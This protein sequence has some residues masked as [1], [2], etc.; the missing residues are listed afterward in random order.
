M[1]KKEWRT[2]HE[3]F[4][5]FVFIIPKYR[6]DPNK[7]SAW[8]KGRSWPVSVGDRI[9]RGRKAR[10]SRAKR[11]QNV[12][13]WDNIADRDRCLSRNR[14]WPRALRTQKKYAQSQLSSPYNNLYGPH[15]A[16]TERIFNAWW[17]KD[18][19]AV[20]IAIAD[21]NR[22]PSSSLPQRYCNWC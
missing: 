15:I 7:N 8:Q 22:P 13:F 14:P 20:S 21:R 9:G 19:K 16:V 1:K 17:L 2:M 5:Y 4:I 10:V 18:H 11:G 3:A 6:R 12:R